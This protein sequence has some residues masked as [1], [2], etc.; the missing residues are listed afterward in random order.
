MT[1]DPSSVERCLPPISQQAG[2]SFVTAAREGFGADR[3]QQM[4]GHEDARTAQRYA[5]ARSAADDAERLSVVLAAQM[6]AVDAEA[7]AS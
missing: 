7:T 1:P 5:H 6:P 3:V 4:A 2:H